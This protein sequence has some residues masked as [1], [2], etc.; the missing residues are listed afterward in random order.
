MLS[1]YI[2]IYIYINIYSYLEGIITPSALMPAETP[3]KRLQME[4]EDERERER[5][6]ERE[7]HIR[8]ANKVGVLLDHL[9][10]GRTQEE[11][12]IQDS[13]DGSVGQGVVAQEQIHAVAVQ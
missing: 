4:I 13:A 7:Y 5:E 3:I 10:W 1:I 2:Y 11:I 9:A 8:F 12:K 6:R